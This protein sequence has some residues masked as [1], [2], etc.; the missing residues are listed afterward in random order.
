[1]RLWMRGMGGILCVAVALLQGCG[2]EAS[3]L[4]ARH[5]PSGFNANF[6]G[7]GLA[8]QDYVTQSR[9]M[10]EKIVSEDG[11]ARSGRI[12][13][14]NAP[15]ELRPAGDCQSGRDKPYRR[16]VLLTH[17]L[18]DAPYS[19][20]ALASFFQKNCFLVMAIL[21]PGHGTQPG[22]LLE[23]TWR[24][25]ARAEAYGTDQLAAEVDEVY[26]AGFS[27]GGALSLYQSLKDDRVRGLFLFAPALEIT[28]MAAWANV[29]KIYSWLI[30]SERWVSIMP[31]SA[32]YRYE[33]FPKNAVAQ[34]HSLIK[35]VRRGLH[36]RTLDI[37]IFTVTSQED[38]TVHTSA[39]LD[40]MAHARHASNKMLLYTVSTNS[41]PQGFRAGSLELVSSV[42]PG[43]RILSSAH[44]AITLPLDDA[45]YGVSGKYG[46][47]TH[48]Y[49]NNPKKYAD[50]S[51]GRGVYFYGELTNKNLQAGTLRRLMVNPHY[52]ALEDSMKNFID[53][54][55]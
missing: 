29:H 1:M 30:P 38:S 36:G 46:N 15:F 52:S 49:P 34:V 37:P 55:P 17:G 26:L 33:S 54:L 25:W 51:E 42:I 19:M 5:K 27:A 22:D 44:T 21:L 6:S 41:V 8:F 10:I 45:Y 9:A 39:T 32:A 31:D 47:C 12:V 43:R 2:G 14:G 11:V 16:G 53:G 28:L 50:C 40:F 48:Y 18:S 7:D 3:P 24:E 4:G 35:E 13:D 20:H 23:V